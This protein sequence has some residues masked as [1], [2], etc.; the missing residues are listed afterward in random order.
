MFID[1]TLKVTPQ[2]IEK[3]FINEK[4]SVYGHIGTHFDVMDKCFPLEYIKRK[5]VVFD[6]S[7]IQNDEIGSEDIDLSKVDR[8]MFVAFHT[9]FIEQV[10]Y[11]E[12]KYFKQHPQLMNELI[13]KLVEKR[14]SLIGIDFAGLR[15]GKEHTPKDAYLADK[16]I[17]VVENLCNLNEVLKKKTDNFFIANTYP[18]N[19]SEMT[20]LPCRVVAE[21]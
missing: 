17:F 7:G 13:D 8:G 19:Y 16:G 1:L 2:M 15:R 10:G 21:I 9:G 6:V 14:I 20:G 11:G 5:G 3:A 18:I 4:K 12:E